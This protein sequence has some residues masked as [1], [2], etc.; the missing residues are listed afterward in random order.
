LE[1]ESGRRRRVDRK[2]IRL[3]I[4]INA[5]I[6]ELGFKPSDVDLSKVRE[7]YETNFLVRWR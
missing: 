1:I 4:L 2:E 7:V 5:G 3:D 6:A